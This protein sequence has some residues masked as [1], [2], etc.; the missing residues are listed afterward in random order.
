MNNILALLKKEFI[1]HRGAFTIAPA[2]V[3]AIFFLTFMIGAW[4]ND[5]N[6]DL[7]FGVT[8]SQ[9]GF[10]VFTSLLVFSV[11]AWGAYLAIGL[12][13]YFAGSFNADRKNNAL[14]FWKSLPVSDLKILGVK[15]LAGV[16]MFPLIIVGWSI[17]TAIIAYGS[18]LMI[19]IGSPALATI[20]TGINIVVFF[21]LIVTLLVLLGTML[22]WYLPFLTFVGLLGILLR[23]WAVPAFVLIMALVSILD[24]ILAL[25]NGAGSISAILQERVEAPFLNV[26]RVFTPTTSAKDISSGDYSLIGRFVPDYLGVTDWVAMLVGL[27][28]AGAFVFAASEYRRRRLEA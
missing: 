17:I 6:W 25:G 5:F 23:S 16:T 21:E 12:F 7:A 1:E 20:N 4:R 28:I 2:I 26:M 8:A 9:S 13:F 11:I 10:D 27:L 24:D 19:S 3:S 14:L 15:V 22:L 18:F